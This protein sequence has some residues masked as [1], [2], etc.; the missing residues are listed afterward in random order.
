M[1]AR[2]GTMEYT[3]SEYRKARIAHLINIDMEEEF[4]YRGKS[5]TKEE[6]VSLV[7]AYKIE[8][9]KK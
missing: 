5:I 9:E 4:I 2:E 1:K 8:K 6:A 3:H 7:E